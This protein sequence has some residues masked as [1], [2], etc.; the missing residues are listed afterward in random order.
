MTAV[1][2]LGA[3]ICDAIDIPDGNSEPAPTPAPT[4]P[5]EPVKYGAIIEPAEPVITA[6]EPIK[7]W[8]AI[9]RKAGQ[10]IVQSNL[11]ASDNWIGWKANGTE[12]NPLE[13]VRCEDVLLE[14][15]GPYI[16]M[17]GA[18]VIDLRRIKSVEAGTSSY[19]IG[20]IKCTDTIGSFRA[21][22]LI[23]DGEGIAQNANDAF[24]AVCLWGKDQGSDICTD[25]QIERF[26]LRD[27]LMATGDNYA[28][29]D[30]ISVERGHDQG[31]IE[32]G[33]IDNCSDAGIDCKG[34]DVRI[35]QVDIANCRQSLKLWDA[36][37]RIGR[38]ISRTPRFAHIL[39]ASDNEQV[40]DE[41]IV[42]DQLELYGDPGRTV[43]AFEGQK[44]VVIKSLVH[45]EA[46]ISELKM[47]TKT[48]KAE[49]STLW[50]NGIQVL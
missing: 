46:E 7:G 11:W 26:M 40:E 2:A 10:S 50:V 9:N 37:N 1:T 45:H 19:G 17:R 15:F 25:W 16:V 27:C 31:L 4:V 18:P 14:R 35:N 13:E 48:N 3:A 20:F 28:N 44:N 23:F 21:V 12:S 32:H 42:I 29:A 24:A 43:V 47:F 39:A 49:G 41:P 30:G 36:S 5:A 8:G 34:Y 6:E 33:L 38:I 22:D